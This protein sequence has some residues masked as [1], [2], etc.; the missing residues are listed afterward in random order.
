MGA[1]PVPVPVHE[2]VPVAVPVPLAPP[3]LRA[4]LQATCMALCG[5]AADG[6]GDVAA[7]ARSP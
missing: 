1:A 4:V 6:G 7:N 3:E 5:C 2:P